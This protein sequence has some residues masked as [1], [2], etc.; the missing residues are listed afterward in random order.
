[1]SPY[2]LAWAFLTGVGVGMMI[3]GFLAGR[4]AKRNQQ[5]GGEAID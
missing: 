3:A 2:L 1:V 4:A 5:E